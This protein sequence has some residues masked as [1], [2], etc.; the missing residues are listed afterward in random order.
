[1][2]A[3]SDDSVCNRICGKINTKQR[4]DAR[5]PFNDTSDAHVAHPKMQNARIQ[6]LRRLIVPVLL[7]D[8][9]ANVPLNMLVFQMMPYV[10]L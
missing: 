10:L 4:S 6:E 1:M 2:S 3:A 5:P 9:E 8:L 7:L